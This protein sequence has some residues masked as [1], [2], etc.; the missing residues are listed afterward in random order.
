MALATRTAVGGSPHL[1]AVCVG[2]SSRRTGGHTLQ[3]HREGPALAEGCTHGAA[4]GGPA[5]C[6]PGCRRAARGRTPACARRRFGH[7]LLPPHPRLL[8]SPLSSRR[9]GPPP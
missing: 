1:T 2:G 3:C 5:R 9:G 6:C 7:L 8:P 4:R